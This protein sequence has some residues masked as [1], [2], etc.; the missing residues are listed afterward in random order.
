[1]KKN[2]RRPQTP[3]STGLPACAESGRVTS[4]GDGGVWGLMAAGGKKAS[5][6][7]H[8][9]WRS[10]K[11]KSKERGTHDY[12]FLAWFSYKAPCPSWLAAGSASSGQMRCQ[13]S[14]R[15]SLRVTSP[16]VAC[17]INAQCSG[18]TVPRL[19]HAATAVWTT[20]QCSASFCCEPMA[21]IAFD[22]ACMSALNH[23]RDI[24]VNTN[25]IQNQFLI[26]K[27]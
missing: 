18:G 1:M 14:G 16:L 26:K 22:S 17:S 19:T 12:R 20:P 25:V 23:E 11:P 24:H 27:I 21:P 5:A 10:H 13:S 2:T 15:S 4:T 6:P 8:G 7:D 3:S 9:Q